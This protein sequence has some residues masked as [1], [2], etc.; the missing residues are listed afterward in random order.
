MGQQATIDTVLRFPVIPVFYNASPQVSLSVFEACYRGGVRAFE[1]TNRGA[2]ALNTF[3]RLKQHAKQL[4]GYIL[5]AGT[6]LNQSDA[7]AFI[8]AGADF[9]VSPCYVESVSDTCYQN[10]IPYMPGCMTVKEIHYAMQAG[11]EI[12]KLFPGEVLGTAFVKAV[13]AVFPAVQLMVTGGV[14]PTPDSLSAW[15]T[16]GV[17][18]VGMGSLLFKKEWIEAGD[19]ASIENA[20]QQCFNNIAS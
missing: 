8:D 14:A 7:A 13:K 4:P 2:N 5:G 18:A 1:F 20:C 12:V 17:S 16:A 10:K 3:K 15:F 9:I 11:C 19:F 6:I